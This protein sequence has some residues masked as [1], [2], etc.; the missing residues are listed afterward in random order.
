MLT[1]DDIL[2]AGAIAGIVIGSLAVLAVI[3]LIVVL[4]R[5]KKGTKNLGFHGIIL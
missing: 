3:A 5:L 4:V 2:S 1:D